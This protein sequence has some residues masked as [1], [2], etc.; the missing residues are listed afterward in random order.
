MIKES[1]LPSV[2]AVVLQACNVLSGVCDP[3]YT[4]RFTFAALLLKYI[5]DTC[6][7]DD[8]REPLPPARFLVPGE[9]RYSA[10]MEAQFRPGNAKRLNSALRALEEENTELT[11]VFRG[12]DFD[13]PTLG[14]SEQKDRLLPML[15]DAFSVLDLSFP[16][17]CSKTSKIAI[18]ASRILLM[19]ASSAGGK[20]GAEFFT[21]PELS[22]LIARLMKVKSGETIFDPYC[23]SASTL[24]TCN[25]EAG[26]PLAKSG[27]ALYGQEINGDTWALAKMN[28]ILNGEDQYQ[29]KLGDSLRDPQYLDTSGR[30]EKF[31]I[32]ISHPPFSVRDW[33]GDEAGNDRFERFSRGVPPRSSGDYAFLSH[34]IASLK[35]GNGRMAVI[36]P[37]GVLFRGGSELQIRESLVREN[38]I[39]AII[40]LPTKLFS[41]TSIGAAILV[42]RNNKS[43]DDVLF[44]DAS[45]SFQA[46]KVQNT[47]RHSDLER[48][49]SCFHD[50]STLNYYSKRASQSD[51]AANDMNLSVAR[52]VGSPLEKNLVNI[53]ALRSEKASLTAELARLEAKRALLIAELV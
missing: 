18:E 23:G 15:L 33:G 27:R 43:T 5:S 7:R 53:P 34:M 11:G 16:S 48:I 24:I 31:D 42:I 14:S 10:L 4:L 51:I 30:L 38:L 26:E 3:A 1:E 12:I 20:R 13:A 29:L 50:R 17:P 21:P 40:A 36:V 6:I 47:L 37:L 49:V 41:S 44:I 19:F 8:S 22:L 52:Y 39:D 35:S 28:M 2:K 46:G 45:R 25:Q 9:A 32:L